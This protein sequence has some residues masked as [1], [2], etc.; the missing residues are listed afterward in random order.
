MPAGA[1]LSAILMVTDVKLSRHGDLNA[2]SDLPVTREAV[3]AARKGKTIALQPCDRDHSRHYLFLTSQLWETI[4]GGK[5]RL[6][7]PR[8]G[9][10]LR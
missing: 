8:L 10:A 1:D 5:D 4:W 7:T 6:A 9:V 2:R 3:S